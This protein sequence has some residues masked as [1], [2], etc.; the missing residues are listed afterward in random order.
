MQLL[1]KQTLA[2]FML[3]NAYAALASP[4]V[5]AGAHQ[6]RAQ[7]R[8]IARTEPETPTNGTEGGLYPRG[9]NSRWSWYDTEETGNPCVSSASS[10]LGNASLY[11]SFCPFKWCLREA[12]K[13]L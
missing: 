11:L 6:R 2:G 13:K 4:S 10:Y 7:H 8:A 12:H 9:P 3:A 1:I 5:H